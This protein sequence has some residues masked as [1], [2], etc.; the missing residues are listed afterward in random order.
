MPAIKASLAVVLVVVILGYALWLQHCEN[1]RLLDD[2]R[3]CSTT[4][5]PEGGWIRSVQSIFYSVS[6]VAGLLAVMWSMYHQ[7]LRSGFSFNRRITTIVTSDYTP[8]IPDVYIPR[9]Q[10]EGL[11]EKLRDNINERARSKF[12]M[13][14]GESGSG[15][16]T[17]MQTLLKTRYRKGVIELS[18]SSEEMISNRARRSISFIEQVQTGIKEKLG[19]LF[20]HPESDGNFLDFVKKASEAR[21]AATGENAHPLIIYIM[22]ESKNDLDYST[23]EDFAKAFASVGTQLSSK[24]HSCKNIVEFSKTAISDEIK[25]LNPSD[26]TPFEVN[27]MTE[28]EFLDIGRQLLAVSKDE[29]DLVEPYLRYFHDWLGGHT[30]ILTSFQARTKSASM[31]SLLFLYRPS[32]VKLS[33]WGKK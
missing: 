13:L 30:K 2:L 4:A 33:P 18:L 7:Y 25:R 26:Q 22:L 24:T 16:T 29:Q 3:M 11:R 31:C 8:D 21:K 14:V 27:A 20:E 28:D 9:Q 10:D 32:P 5:Q 1:Q 6:S 15:K 19:K 12:F 23:M 17:L